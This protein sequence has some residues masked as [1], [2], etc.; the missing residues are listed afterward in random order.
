MFQTTNQGWYRSTFFDRTK[1]V[2]SKKNGPIF[3]TRCI[4]A[5]T[6]DGVLPGADRNSV[7]VW[8]RIRGVQWNHQLDGFVFTGKS[9]PE[10]PVFLMV[11]TMVKAMVSGYPPYISNPI[12]SM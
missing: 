7:K 3:R 6:D 10:P 2:S 12:G 8:H 5:Q 4:L 11:K 1:S 9:E